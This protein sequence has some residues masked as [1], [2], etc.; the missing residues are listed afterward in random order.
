V[1]VSNSCGAT[2]QSSNAILTVN[3]L[4]TITVSSPEICN[5]FSTQ[6]TAGGGTSYLWSTGATTSTISVSPSVTTN[7]TVTGTDANGCQSQATST[8][9]VNSNPLVSLNTSSSTICSGGSGTN[10]IIATT[11]SGT[12]TYSY[13]WQYFNGTSW[14]NTGTNTN[15]LNATPTSTREYRVIVSDVKGCQVISSTH[16]VTVVPDPIN[17]TLNTK[18]PNQNDICVGTNVSSTFNPGTDGVSCGDVFQFSTNGGGNW[19]TYIPGSAISTNGLSQGTIVQ[20]R[21]R[22]TN[23]AT[24]I[25]CSSNTWSILS[26]WTIVTPP[27][28][29]TSSSQISCSGGGNGSINLT[30][31]GSV[32]PFTFDWSGPNGFTSNLED[33]TNL[34]SGDYTVV[35]STPSGCSST[36]SVTV[37]EPASLVLTLVGGDALCNGTSS[38]NIDLTVSGGTPTYTYLWSNGSTTQD[39]TNLSAGSYSIQVTDANNCVATSSIIISQPSQPLQLSTTSQDA[40]CYGSST[41]SIDMTVTGGTSPYTYSWSNSSTSEDLSNVV[42]GTYSVIVT[43]DNGCSQSTSVIISQPSIITTSI[44]SFDVSCFGGA[45]GVIY[46]TVNGGTPP[47]TYLWSNGQTTEDLAALPAGTYSVTVTDSKGCTVT[48]SKTI[49][50][51]TILTTVVTTTNVSC[52]GGNNGSA[53]VTASGGTPPYLYMW[54]TGN[55]QSSL[56]NLS[57]GNYQITVSDN[58]GCTKLQFVNISQPPPVL[59]SSNSATISS[60]QTTP[61][62]LTATASG[63]NPGYTYLWSTG[64][65]TNTISVLPTSNTLYTVTVTDTKGCVGSSQSSVTISQ[66]ASLPNAGQVYGPSQ[67][68]NY[69]LSGATAT[70]SVNPVVGASGY[71]WS[72]PSNGVITVGPTNTNVLTV[73]FTGDYVG[74]DFSVTTYDGCSTGYSDTQT[75]TIIDDPII[76]GSSCGIPASSIK[77]YVV[78]NS[79]P[80]LTYNWTPPYG[81]NLLSG[82]GNDTCQLKFST[83]FQTMSN[84]NVSVSTVFGTFTGTKQLFRNATAPTQIIGPSTVCADGT[85]IYTYYVDSVST[86]TSYIWNVGNG[87]TIIGSSTNDTISVKFST[88]FIGGNFSCMAVN[89]CGSSPMRYFNVSNNNLYANIGTISGPGDLCPF[90]GQTTTYSVSPQSGTFT[91]SVPSGMTI[92]SG[93]GTNVL[94]V[95]VSTTFTPGNISVSLNNGCGGSISSTKS[96]ST[97][98]SNITASP[99]QGPSSVCSLIGTSTTATYSISPISG[100]NY[101]WIVPANS[102]IVSGQ[103]SNSINVTFQNG[104]TGGNIQVVVTGGCGNPV[105]MTR[106]INLNLPSFNISGVNCT[107]NGYTNN[108][109]VTA[110]TGALSYS[111]TVPGNAQITSGQGTNAISVFFPSNFESTSCVNNACDSI[112]LTVQFGCGSVTK[113]KRIGLLTV[114]PNVTGPTQACFPDTIT[115]VATTSPRITSYI[116]NAPNGVS[117][118]GPTTNMTAKAKINSTFLGGSFSVMGVNTCGSSPMR[119]FYVSKVCPSPSNFVVSGDGEVVE[120]QQSI[121]TIDEILSDPEYIESL[122]QPLDFIVYPNPGKDKVNLRVFKGN[123][124]YYFISI[125]SIIGHSVYSSLH[126]SEDILDVS[127]FEPGIFLITVE[128]KDGYK[129]TKQLIIEK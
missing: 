53:S 57:A 104:F 69:M 81:V 16:T 117:F 84:V 9:T 25:G 64:A 38:G 10:N 31:S 24:G 96:L 75:V 127:K 12:P 92:Q 100:V 116:W 105:T 56:S 40:L 13:Q 108:Y 44:S 63:G 103:G 82:Q 126:E 74:G 67:A 27:I 47:Y 54:N 118:V 80:G 66:S 109:S 107:D 46:L 91:W 79:I 34:S 68:Y 30:V 37:S 61:V 41:G 59:V 125:R 60:C 101:N 17:P 119:Y 33:I 110:Q 18:T 73:Q 85:T 62:T 35:V 124:D 58:K 121:T 112:R 98:Q 14:L 2:T 20:I 6:I 86:A 42:A 83:Y 128:G 23:C 11:S 97:I 76:V 89:Q 111:W 88:T 5:G 43:D 72:L 28:L 15:T 39:V 106:A 4:P 55:T 78:S 94:T 123:S 95:F 50:Q 129:I 51:P 90:L 120:S 8:V 1:I 32:G 93:Q 49:T 114:A 77:T 87:C 19:S 48:T 45:N 99:I 29:S 36:T 26:Q 22:R 21:G 102:T 70:Y 7:Y 52:D 65:T 115:L 122:K 71:I 113:A 3:P